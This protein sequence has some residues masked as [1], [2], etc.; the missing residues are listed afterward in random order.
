[1]N[2]VFDLDGTICFSGQPISQAITQ[3]LW[4]LHLAGH[5]IIIASARPIR[6]IYPVIPKWLK[7]FDMIGGNGAFI[8][9]DQHIQVTA[10]DCFPELAKLIEQHQLPYLADS[11]WDYAYSGD[12][13]HSIYQ[14]IDPHRLA[15]IH[16]SYLSLSSIV[17][18]VLF[19]DDPAIFQQV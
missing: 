14:N 16:Q 19:T 8:Q 17:K 7:S 3:S 18:L 12:T 15:T 5:T 6:D 10:F 1:M 9:K 11:D 13:N 4:Q 2:F